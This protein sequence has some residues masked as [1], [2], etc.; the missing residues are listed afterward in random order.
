M[1]PEM[2]TLTVAMGVYS[3]PQDGA[4]EVVIKCCVIYI[5]F[6]KYD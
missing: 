6:L 3:V 2:A 1:V 4:P 5:N